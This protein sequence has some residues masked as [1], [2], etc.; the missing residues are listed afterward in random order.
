MDVDPKTSRHGGSPASGLVSP[1]GLEDLK[2]AAAGGVVLV[3][4]V[5]VD[6]EKQAADRTARALQLERRRVGLEVLKQMAAFGSKEEAI[7][8]D[9]TLALKY[10]DELIAQTGGGI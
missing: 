3:P 1:S 7:T 4:R 9:T 5:V 8:E 2:P 10:A 6:A